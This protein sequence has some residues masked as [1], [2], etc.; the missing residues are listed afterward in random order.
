MAP[1]DEDTTPFTEATNTEE[2]LSMLKLHG[3]GFLFM[4]F[5]DRFENWEIVW[6]SVVYHVTIHIEESHR[7]FKYSELVLG[8]ILPEALEQ[9]TDWM[10]STTMTQQFDAGD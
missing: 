5:T 1:Q 8:N 4:E 3:R 10:F 6:D 2:I 7:S 9:V